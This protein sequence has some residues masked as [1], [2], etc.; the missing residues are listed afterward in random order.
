MPKDPV[1]EIK[2]TAKAK[3]IFNQHT[4]CISA[5]PL[6]VPSA[7]GAMELVAKFLG[8]PAQDL[9]TDGTDHPLGCKN[10][11]TQNT[12]THFSSQAICN[13]ECDF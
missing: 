6:Y 8:R 7:F 10:R 12:D 4:I 9:R 3:N 2:A 11:L 13:R 5:I 1:K